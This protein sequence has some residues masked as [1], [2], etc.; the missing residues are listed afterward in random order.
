VIYEKLE[1][2]GIAVGPFADTKGE[3]ELLTPGERTA[4]TR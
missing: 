2:G 1:V 3:H 4:N